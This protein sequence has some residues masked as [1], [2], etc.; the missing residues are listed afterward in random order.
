MPTVCFQLNN[1]SHSSSKVG[2]SGSKLNPPTRSNSSLPSVYMLCSPARSASRIWI[3]G[4]TSVPEPI[5]RSR[6]AAKLFGEEKISASPDSRLRPV[7][8]SAEGDNSRVTFRI[9]GDLTCRRIGRTNEGSARSERSTRDVYSASPPISQ[10]DSGKLWSTIGH[11]A[12][13]GNKHLPPTP[14]VDGMCRNLRRG[15]ATWIPTGPGGT[16]RRKRRYLSSRRRR[17]KCEGQGSDKWCE[18]NQRGH[19]GARRIRAF[20]VPTM[21]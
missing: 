13:C 20:G 7:V 11:G 14:T 12:Q 3:K 8:P 5:T 19:K 1:A 10:N 4:F 2:A 6:A 21:V 16:R 18:A 9:T 15:S 17:I